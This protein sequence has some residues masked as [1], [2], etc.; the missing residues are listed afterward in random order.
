[1][2]EK[3]KLTKGGKAQLEAE[4]KELIEVKRPD[5]RRQL[6]EA[7]AEGDL[8]ENADYDAARNLQAKI[9]GRITEIQ[10]ILSNAEV[11]KETSS[12]KK[13]SLGSV[14]KI[15]DVKTGEVEEYKI[16]G[17][18]EA[19]PFKGLISQTCTLGQA[20]AGKS[21]G[22]VVDVKSKEPYQ[23]EIIEIKVL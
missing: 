12:T 6:A 21:V 8:S 16:V 3:Y 22:A 18:V 9:E 19:D 7:R 14:V 11:I 4:L 5:V 15:K 20:L 1:M 10:E 2:A 17:S 23:V 13:V